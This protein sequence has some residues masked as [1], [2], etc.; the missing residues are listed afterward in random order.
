MKPSK[1]DTLNKLGV[2]RE[3]SEVKW[4]KSQI[5][6]NWKIYFRKMGDKPEIEEVPIDDGKNKKDSPSKHG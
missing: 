1:C 3:F 5:D 6:E 2:R 4:E